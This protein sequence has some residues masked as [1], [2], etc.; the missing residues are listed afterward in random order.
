MD[1]D[2]EGSDNG[3]VAPPSAG[4][5][6][7]RSEMNLQ[8]AVTEPNESARRF[9]SSGVPAPTPDSI[10]TVS[11]GKPKQAANVVNLATSYCRVVG[12]QAPTAIPDASPTNVTK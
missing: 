2:V 12:S 10:S 1:S 9:V 6:Q 8:L 5:D 11:L 4:L 7:S 3:V